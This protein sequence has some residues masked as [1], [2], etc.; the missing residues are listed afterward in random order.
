MRRMSSAAKLPPLAL[1]L[2]ALLAA[3]CIEG[4]DPE[5]ERAKKALVIGIDGMR[6]D[7]LEVAET[8]NLDGLIATGAW[9]LSASTQRGAPTVSGPGWSSLL[10]GV[11]AD[12]H[13]IHGNGGWD[14]FD[15]SYPTLLGRAHSLGLG[16]AA[17]IHWLPIQTDIIE[18]EVLDVATP[19]TDDELVTEGMELT[20]FDHDLGVYFVAFDELDAAGH[21]G[22]YGNEYPGYVATVERIDGY[23]GRLLDARDGR[24][25]RAD[26]DWLVVVTSDHGGLGTGH[27]G[28]SDD[29]R[30]I[31]L[32]FDGP[33]LVPGEIV[34]GTLVS[35][36]DVHPTVMQ[37]LGFAPD[38]AWGLDGHVRGLE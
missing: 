10:T 6:A 30:T 23:V 12:K 20:L 16:T 35:H 15:R 9:S 37:F 5:P 2:L 28:V 32:V 21:D 7:A 29:E 19:A 4:P 11:D 34:T 17:S 14:Q 13:L 1:L 31:P 25:G 18:D 3:G 33:G 22:G 36:M 24:T 8:P 38:P 27:G 26:E